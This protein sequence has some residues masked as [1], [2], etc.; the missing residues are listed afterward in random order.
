MNN[1]KEISR[2]LSLVLRHKPEK[3]DL[4]LDGNGWASVT[5][6][7][8]KLKPTITME[9]LKEIV[10]SNDKKR[11]AF[12]EDKSKI[13][14][15]QGHSIKIDLAL[16]SVE[17]PEV[18]YHGTAKRFL[19]SIKKSGLQKQSRTHVHLSGNHD[20]AINVGKRH[21]KPIVLKIDTK[22]MS[23]DGHKFYI[24][25]NEVWLTDNVPVEYILIEQ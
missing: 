16:E 20:T 4:V 1:N 18:L 22:K 2:F 25:E 5:E 10:E 23:I 19:D 17:P 14:A 9:I 12:N 15:S 6:L 11:F 8:S 24:S 3:I 21:G 13:R 7:L